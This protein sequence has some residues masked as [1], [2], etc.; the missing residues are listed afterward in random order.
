MSLESGKLK[1]K[2]LIL[3]VAF[4]I[5]LS[6]TGIAQAWSNG[7]DGGNGFG[8]HDWI[9]KEALD[10]IPSYTSWL[11]Y[12]AAQQATDDPD[13]IFHDY[14]YHV[15]DIW[16]ETY[17]NSP[18][19]VQEYFDQAIQYLK[20]KD[21]HHASIAVGLMSHYWADTNNPLHTDQCDDEDKMLSNYE[22]AVNTRTNEPDESVF[23]I[24][25]MV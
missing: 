8:T 12:N 14:Y 20:Q 17:G 19:K 23:S 18:L 15:Y 21:Y 1:N 3:A 25:M 2:L 24:V 22:L 4:L 6:S 9:L 16:G 7:G 13:T 10:T 5:F 11:D